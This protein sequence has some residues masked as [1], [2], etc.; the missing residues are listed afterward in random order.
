MT[1][2]V[3]IPTPL[4]SLTDGLADISVPGQ[5]VQ[6][7]I[8]QIGQ[9]YPG[10]QEKLCDEEGN[11]RMYVNIYL[12]DEDIRYLDNLKTKLQDGDKMYIIPAIAGG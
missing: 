12:N 11:L 4:R 9:Q 7:V 3:K 6:D 5:T 8:S 1:V 10:L 2:S